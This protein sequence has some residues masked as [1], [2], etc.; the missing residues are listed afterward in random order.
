MFR[1]WSLHGSL[2]QITRRLNIVLWTKIWHKQYTSE[3]NLARTFLT[4]SVLAIFYRLS[5]SSRTICIC[6]RTKDQRDRYPQSN[7]G[8]NTGDRRPSFER[9]YEMGAHCQCDRVAAGILRNERMASKFCLPG[10][11]RRLGIYRFRRPIVDCCVDHCESHAIKA[12]TANPV[13]SMR[14]E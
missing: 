6:D 14:Y 13:E 1:C 4:F 10:K 5:G 12:A 11:Y 8:I 9:V 3:K 7:G 2:L